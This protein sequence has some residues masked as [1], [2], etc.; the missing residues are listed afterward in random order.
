[1]ISCIRVSFC[2]KK[3][4]ELFSFVNINAEVSNQVKLKFPK[5][6]GRCNANN[7][8]TTSSLLVSLISSVKRALEALS[9]CDLSLIFITGFIDIQAAS[10]T[11][12]RNASIRVGIRVASAFSDN[13]KG[14]DVI[15]SLLGAQ[16][17][18]PPFHTTQW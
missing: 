2:D 17:N 12:P 15:M 6:F 5:R 10:A 7:D 18:R 4:L 3:G 9:R 8:A 14:Q 16:H 11:V 13:F 1:M